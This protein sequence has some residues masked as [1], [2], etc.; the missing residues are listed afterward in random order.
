[1]PLR[2][3]SWWNISISGRNNKKWG[4]G[5][6]ISVTNRKWRYLS[7]VTL[8]IVICSRDCKE[9]RMVD[10][11][12]VMLK[13]NKNTDNKVRAWDHWLEITENKVQWY[14]PSV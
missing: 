2:K 13:V 6:S 8:K 14:L 3:P 12:V 7:Q 4:W 10:S 11:F 9:E 1:M 5:F